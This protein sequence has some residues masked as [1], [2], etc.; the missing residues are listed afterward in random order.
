MSRRKVT[1]N[2]SSG[3]MKP[4]KTIAKSNLFQSSRKYAHGS[5]QSAVILTTHSNVK[6]ARMRCSIARRVAPSPTFS[7]AST[8]S[9]PTTRIAQSTVDWNLGCSATQ[10]A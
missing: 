5:G 1:E 6:I 7:T 3:S 4:R 9:A 8:S 10:R 2:E